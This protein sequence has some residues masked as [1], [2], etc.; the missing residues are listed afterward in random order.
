[1]ILRLPF[2]EKERMQTFVHFSIVFCLK[3]AL[4]HWRSMT[5]NFLIFYTSGDISF[6]FAAFLL[7]IF[8][9]TVLSSS[10]VN[11]PSWLLI[12]FWIGS[13]VTLV[14]SWNVLS[15]SEVFFHGW[16]LLFFLSKCSSFCSLHLLFVMLIRIVCLLLSFWFYWFGLE[17]ILVVLFWYMSVSFVLVCVGFKFPGISIC[18]VS[19]IS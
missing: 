2:L 17:C 9:S 7:L 8:S 5:S 12:I 18:W 3:T 15:I 16:Q 19:F 6:R 14:D 4:H 1:M 13:S 10:S 11:C